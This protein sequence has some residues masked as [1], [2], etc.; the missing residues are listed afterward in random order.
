FWGCD[1]GGIRAWGAGRS[2]GA[3]VVPWSPIRCAFGTS[4]RPRHQP[5]L[6]GIARRTAAPEGENGDHILWYRLMDDFDADLDVN[7]WHGTNRFIR[8]GDRVFRTGSING[9]GGEQMGNT[10]NYL[11]VTA[12]G[13]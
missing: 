12:F 8:E 6:A 10:S 5:R 4:R 2:A 11:Y 3:S 1:P 7:E 9:R 13:R